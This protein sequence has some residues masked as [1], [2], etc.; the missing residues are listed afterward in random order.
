M[1]R[2]AEILQQLKVWLADG[3]ITEADYQEV[4]HQAAYLN[5]QEASISQAQFT[6]ISSHFCCG[7]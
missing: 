5:A 4:Y 7:L 2:A 3:L 1:E 6:S